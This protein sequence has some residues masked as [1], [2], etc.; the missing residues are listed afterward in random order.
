MSSP[1]GHDLPSLLQLCRAQWLQG[2]ENT[3]QIV[4]NDHPGMRP[5]ILALPAVLL[6]AEYQRE[7]WVG[8]CPSLPRRCEL[9]LSL[10]ANLL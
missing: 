1:E 9:L 2:Q 6:E 10:P 8:M 7:R 5:E 3:W 4:L